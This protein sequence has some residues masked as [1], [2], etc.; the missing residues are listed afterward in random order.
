MLKERHRRLLQVYSS[1]HRH[2]QDWFSP[3]LRLAA[4][5]LSVAVTWLVF[6]YFESTYP[7][8]ILLGNG[9]SVL[10][11]GLLFNSFVAGAVFGMIMFAIIIEGEYILGLRRRVYA[12]MGENERA[13]GSAGRK[14]A[15]AQRRARST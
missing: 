10:L 4:L 1:M 8:A 9:S 14:G 5:L 3:K 15:R 13:K 11:S 7:Q 12:I 2:R 6:R